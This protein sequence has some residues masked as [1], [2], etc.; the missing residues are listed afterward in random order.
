MNRARRQICLIATSAGLWSLLHDEVWAA[1]AREI[2][3]DAGAKLHALYSVSPDAREL[4]QRARGILVFPRIVKAGFML[5]GQ[6]GNGVLLLRGRKAAYYNISAASFGLQA[7]VQSFSYVLFFMNNRALDYLRRSNG[8]AIGSGPSVVVA[9]KGIARSL[10]STT[11]TQD[12]YAFPFGQKG[13]MAGLG[14]EGSKI[15]PIQPGP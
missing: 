8:W 9:D 13:L 4:G 6:S 1:S 5:G 12:V 14:L 2:D 11:L 3:R 15:T 10:T 7:G